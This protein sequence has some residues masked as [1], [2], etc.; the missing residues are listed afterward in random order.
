MLVGGG[1]NGW[2]NS[3]NPNNSGSGRRASAQDTEED[4]LS[5]LST[6]RSDNG[7]LDGLHG[8]VSHITKPL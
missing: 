5:V 4:A 6:V 3:F 7:G 8:L 2:D 1:G